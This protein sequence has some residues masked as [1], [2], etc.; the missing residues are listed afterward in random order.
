MMTD[1]EVVESV[2]RHISH[3]TPFALMRLGDGEMYLLRGTSPRSGFWNKYVQVWGF[4]EEKQ[5]LDSVG[6]YTLK[7][8][9][10]ADVVGLLDKRVA[11]RMYIRLREEDWIPTKE[12]LKKWRVNLDSR[13][14]CSHQIVRTRELGTVEAWQKLLAGRPVHIISCNVE[15]LKK[16]KISSLLKADVSY[17]QVPNPTSLLDREEILKSLENIKPSV[18]LFGLSV[19]GKDIGITLRDEYGKISIDMGATLD[20]WA[21]LETRPWFKKDGGQ[22]YLV[23]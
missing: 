17:T 13:K 8:L 4:E 11:K 10:E 6:K 3:N 22:E 19:L 9:R 23:V 5:A 18:V 12:E 15:Q 20:A 16:N 21:G 2:R 1:M 7:A 14:I